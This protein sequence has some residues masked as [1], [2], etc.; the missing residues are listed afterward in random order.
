MLILKELVWWPGTESNRPRQPF[1]G[2]LPNWPS[3]LESA[4]VTDSK[5][6]L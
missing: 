1:Q 6:L 4:D 3:G 5:K 2:L